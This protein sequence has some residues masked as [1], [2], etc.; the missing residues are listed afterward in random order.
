MR[1]VYEQSDGTITCHACHRCQ[2]SPIG[3]AKFQHSNNTDFDPYFIE[4]PN[5]G[6]I[7]ECC[8]RLN[9]G[10]DVAHNSHMLFNK[11]KQK[12]G[13]S[14]CQIR[15]IQTYCILKAAKE[16]N[17]YV[18]LETVCAFFSIRPTEIYALAKKMSEK[19]KLDLNFISVNGSI[20]TILN[21]MP[22]LSYVQRVKI[23]N[24]VVKHMKKNDN[25]I[26]SN[27]VVGVIVV[28][29]LSDREL[30]AFYSKYLPLFNISRGA[31]NTCLA[32]FYKT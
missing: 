9:L 21:K 13:R 16:N 19:I 8:A 27:V 4:A 1:E 17:F 2:L 29:E 11:I 22:D 30:E 31:V 14:S 23:M 7:W 10:S 24:M 5:I 6:P 25:S 3:L 32:K 15:V 18:C 26:V 20:E 28:L 12:I